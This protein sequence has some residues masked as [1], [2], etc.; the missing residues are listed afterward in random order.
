MGVRFDCRE[1]DPADMTVRAAI[2]QM[3]AAMPSVTEHERRSPPH[4]PYA[5]SLTES[6]FKAVIDS[7]IAVGFHASCPSGAGR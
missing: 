2:N 5:A 7:A 4:V 6:H 3:D 1:I